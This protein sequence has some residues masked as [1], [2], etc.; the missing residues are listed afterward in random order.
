M[1]RRM[2]WSTCV[3]PNW[4]KQGISWRKELPFREIRRSELSSTSWTSARESMRSCICD[5]ISCISAAA[6]VPLCRKTLKY[7]KRFLSKATESLSSEATETWLDTALSNLIYFDLFWACGWIG[8]PLKVHPK[9]WFCDYVLLLV[10]CT[11]YA[12]RLLII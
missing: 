11:L 9:F 6:R 12:W 1:T 10:E 5:R 3:I 7:C 4:G 8:Y 2:G